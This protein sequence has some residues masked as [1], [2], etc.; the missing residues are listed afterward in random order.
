M[1]YGTEHPGVRPRL[2]QGD[3]DHHDAV[4]AAVRVNEAVRP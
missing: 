3:E 2:V 4:L 1:G